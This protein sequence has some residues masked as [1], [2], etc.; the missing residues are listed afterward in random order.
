MNFLKTL[1]QPEMKLF[2]QNE[3]KANAKSS[4]MHNEKE[5]DLNS[6]SISLKKIKMRNP[7]HDK[8]FS[9]R[10]NENEINLFVSKSPNFQ[11][12]MKRNKTSEHR[13]HPIIQANPA[14]TKIS[15]ELRNMNPTLTKNNFF[16]T[17]NRI[18]NQS[19]HEN[20]PIVNLQNNNQNEEEFIFFKK[21]KF[22]L[23][24]AID[25]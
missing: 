5:N 8:I 10:I 18:N 4:L 21:V 14:T 24:K 11:I 19:R 13:K 20:N 7:S 2:N 22:F 9:P 3:M 16:L 12:L 15:E 1:R 6:N 17:Y 23:L 25:S